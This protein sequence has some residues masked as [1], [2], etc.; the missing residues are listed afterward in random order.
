MEEKKNILRN[1]YLLTEDREKIEKLDS[2]ITKECEE[3]EWK[4]LQKVLGNLDTQEGNNNIWTQMKE[5]F[6]KKK[7]PL[8][9]G[10]KNIEGKVITN[11]QEKDKIILK[12]FV[13]RMRKR[14]EKERF[15]ELH[16]I[17]IYFRKDF[18]LQLL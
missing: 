16:K 1:K 2:K 10:V 3:R 6:P 13:H 7:K 8:P 14:P 12:H 18:K 9:A 5:A 4:K 11:P 17:K 15:K